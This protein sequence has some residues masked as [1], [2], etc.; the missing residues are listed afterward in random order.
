MNHGALGIVPRAQ[1]DHQIFGNL[2]HLPQRSTCRSS[3]APKR[4]P[5]A[6]NKPPYPEWTFKRL[7]H[8]ATPPDGGKAALRPPGTPRQIVP[9]LLATCPAP[10]RPKK[11]PSAARSPTSRSTAIFPR[12]PEKRPP[13]HRHISTSRSRTGFAKHQLGR[14]KC[15]LHRNGPSNSMPPSV[16][17]HRRPD[18]GCAR[19][20]PPPGPDRAK[21]CSNQGPPN[22]TPRQSTIANISLDAEETSVRASPSPN[23]TGHKFPSGVGFRRTF[24]RFSQCPDAAGNVIWESGRHQQ[25]PA[26]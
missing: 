7:P 23:K 9:R 2:R 5:T 12:R 10:T 19:G 21:A 22:T 6:T 24:V 16:S 14:P 18:A 25:L 26:S 1:P 17:P 13:G 3:A 15:I 11:T 20:I 4:L 8:R